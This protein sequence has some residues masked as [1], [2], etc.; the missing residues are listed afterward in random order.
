MN[1]MLWYMFCKNF[2]DSAYRSASEKI[3][4]EQPQ[5]PSSQATPE[6]TSSV[7]K[8]VQMSQSEMIYDNRS[9]V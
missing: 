2:L 7:C 6:A 3:I 4:G 9:A 5:Q 8:I 1:N